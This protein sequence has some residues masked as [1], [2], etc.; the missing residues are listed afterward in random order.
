MSFRQIT[1]FRPTA[2]P[3]DAFESLPGSIADHLGD[4]ISAHSPDGTYRYVSAASKELLGYEPD[5][6]IGTSAYDHFH[7]DDAA[8]VGVAHRS[9]LEGAPYTVAYRLRRKDNEY[10]WVETTTR[11]ITDPGTNAVTEILCST[12]AL[13]DRRS[14]EALSSQEYQQAVNRIQGILDGELI[15]P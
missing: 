2:R 10:V 4:M 6:L 3:A 5:E 14:V 1:P 15:E 9:T 12:R 13:V 11:I 7:P 8:K